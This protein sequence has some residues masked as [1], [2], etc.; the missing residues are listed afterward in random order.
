MSF[1]IQ[2][3]NQQDYLH[4]IHHSVTKGGIALENLFSDLASSTYYNVQADIFNAILT[5]GKPEQLNIYRDYFNFSHLQ[6]FADKI[7]PEHIGYIFNLEGN[8]QGIF[9][10]FNPQIIK[11]LISVKNIEVLNYLITYNRDYHIEEFTNILEENIFKY[12]LQGRQLDILLAIKDNLKPLCLMYGLSVLHGR[13]DID[14]LLYLT[15][16]QVFHPD[17]VLKTNMVSESIKSFDNKNNPT[18]AVLCHYF[19]GL[20]STL[21]TH[22]KVHEFINKIEFIRF[23]EDKELLVAP[24]CRAL[25]NANPQYLNCL[26]ILMHTSPAMYKFVSSFQLHEQLSEDLPKNTIKTTKAKI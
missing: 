3:K 16:N 6:L 25:Y 17:I 13:L 10:C 12:S 18:E 2:F 5:Y 4:H 11:Q 23:T 26:Q 9:L 1:D 15:D 24:L 20:I 21:H 14:A 19:D 8:T 7:K 22:N